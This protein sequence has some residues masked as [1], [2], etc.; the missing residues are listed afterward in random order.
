ML[1]AY[2]DRVSSLPTWP[3]NMRTFSFVSGTIV[4]PIL[5]PIAVDFIKTRM[6]F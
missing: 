1:Q 3:L 4:F 2:Y 6:N 5:L